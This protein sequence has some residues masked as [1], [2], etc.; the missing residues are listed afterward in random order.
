MKKFLLP[1]LAV[2]T[3]IDLQGQ[4]T[5]I[6]SNR[7]LGWTFPL[8]QT[9][10]IYVSST[11]QT[12]WVTDGTLAGTIPLSDTIKAEQSNGSSTGLYNGKYIFSGGTAASGTELYITDGTPGGTRLLSDINPGAASSSPDDFVLLNGFLYFTADNPT[13]GR[14]LWRTDGTLTTLVKDIVPGIVGSNVETGYDLFSTGTYLLFKANTPSSG[15]ELWRS[16]GTDAGTVLLKDIN[17]NT[18]SSDIGI[19]SQFNNLV[20]FAANDGINGIEIWK[21]DGTA[22]GTT[23]LKD[24]NPGPTGSVQTSDIISPLIFNNHAFFMANDGTHGNEIW[25]T[26]GTDAGTSLLMD[27][28][29]GPASSANALSVL[30]SV[31]A[32]NKFIFTSYNSTFT[33]NQLWESDG[34]PAGTKLF[35]DFFFDITDLHFPFIFTPLTINTQT[36]IPT[37]GQSLF[38]GNKFFFMETT[39]AEGSELWVSDGVDGTAAHTHIVKDIFP[40]TGS[41]DFG[42]YLYTSTTFFFPATDGINGVELWKTDGT[43]AG[44]SMVADIN[45]GA[46][47]S[48]P[49]LTLFFV[50]NG[51][52]LFGANNG[53]SPTETDLYALD[54]T[55]TT[56]PIKLLDFTVTPKSAD[57]VLNWRTSQEINSKNYTIQRSFDGRNFEPVGTVAASGTAATGKAY[58]FIDPGVINSGKSIIYYRL[59]STDIN[60]VSTFSPVITLKLNGTGKWNVRLLGNPVSDNIKVVLSGITENVRLSVVDIY[61]KKLYSGV[62]PAINGQIS[63]PAASLARGSYTLITE[64]LNERKV[65]QFVK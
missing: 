47:S 33:R 24:I 7:S 10:S 54:G 35:K 22:S 39:A 20:L 43:D 42:L 8:N 37:L 1:L 14:E 58:S 30:S 50:V 51:K 27:I 53:D 29:P 38:Q 63:I 3:V 6:N 64:T 41:N 2:F 40:G 61:G 23:I 65:I 36:P 19:F 31:I 60:G 57:A 18:A 11:D 59:L 17:N 12:I 15:I 32:G 49:E 52:V 55:F 13:Y 28:E 56:L 46:D 26:D 25:V 34:T 5:Q 48:N 9:K 4:V 45:P 21:T 62:L 44:T 16:D